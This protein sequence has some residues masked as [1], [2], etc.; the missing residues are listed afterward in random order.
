MKAYV[1]ESG[2]LREPTAQ[3]M[4]EAAKQGSVPASQTKPA[5]R[6][7][8]RLPDGT[9]GVILDE[10]TQESLKACVQAD[11]SVVMQHTC[12]DAKSKAGKQ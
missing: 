10:S 9:G 8:V 3:E 2:R 11:G 1:D 5:A 7:E 12:E 6:K 4:A